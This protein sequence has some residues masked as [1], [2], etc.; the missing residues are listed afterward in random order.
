MYLSTSGAVSVFADPFAPLEP[1]API[2][3]FVSWPF[4]NLVPSLALTFRRLHD[5]G[6]SAWYYL[7]S[8]IPAAGIF[9]MIIFLTA[10][11]MYPQG[12]KYY[13]RRHV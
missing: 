13:Y 4:I 1:V 12:N 6:R 7:F 11:T 3:I 2:V 5:T 10:P 9:I 8:L